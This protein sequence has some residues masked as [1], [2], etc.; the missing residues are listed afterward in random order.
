M[1]T[2][3]A[4]LIWLIVAGVLAIAEVL[5]LD[6]ILIMTAAAAGLA[7]GGAALG[8]PVAG[9]VAVF[10]VGALGMLFLVRP[11]ARRS[12][13]RGP[14]ALTGV[15]RLIGQHAVVVETVDQHN[16][17]VKL[18]GEHWSARAYDPAQVL[19]I[20]RTVN[21]MEIKGAVALVWGDP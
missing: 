6:L 18:H 8:L 14:H 17:L 11:A 12:L 5:S 2:V 19:E 3:P 1:G 9:Q 21:V 20:G 16:G 10:A 7:A 13:D 4:W 15:D